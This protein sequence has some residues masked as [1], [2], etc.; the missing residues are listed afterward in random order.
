MKS[1][2]IVAVA[3]VATIVT[4][5]GCSNEGSHLK[6]LDTLVERAPCG[7]TVTYKD[8]ELLVEITKSCPAPAPAEA[9]KPCEAT[10]PVA[11]KEPTPADK[12]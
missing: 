12:K 11:Q 7:A 8:S 2:T 10:K 9:P 4:F 1:H 5:A 3:V 6:A